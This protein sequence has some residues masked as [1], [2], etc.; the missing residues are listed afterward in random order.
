MVV[1]QAQVEDVLFG[2]EGAAAALP[3]G[4]TVMLSST[5]PAAYVRGL[6][7]RLAG[8]GL[9]L[10]DAPVSGGAV[11]AGKGELTIMASGTAEA[12]AAAEPRS[13]PA[14][15][16]S[17]AS[18]PSPASARRSRRSTSCSPASTWSAPPRAWRSAWR[19]APIPRCSTR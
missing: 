17:T 3:A 1:N 2:G 12:F 13:R 6:G 16:R 5:V 8:Q 14:P 19:S 11:A 7:E 10:L 18:A 4:A 15:G 9:H